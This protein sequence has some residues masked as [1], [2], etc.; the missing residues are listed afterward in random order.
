VRKIKEE[1]PSDPLR[2]RVNLPEPLSG[3]IL[4]CLAKSKEERFDSFDEICMHLSRIDPKPSHGSQKAVSDNW[5]AILD[6]AQ[7]EAA[8]C[9]ADVVA[10]AHLLLAALSYGCEP[11]ASWL[12]ARD[13]MED[14]ICDKIRASIDARPKANVS[15]TVRFRRSSRRVIGLA[16]SLAERETGTRPTTKHLIK[17]LLGEPSTRA[18][19][20]FALNASGAS[21]QEIEALFDQINEEF[22]RS[23]L[24]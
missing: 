8:R 10:P 24:D 2:L 7:S 3:V 15:A 19:L 20:A 9:G 14:S 5:T 11:L 17:P 1:I 18:T 12:S 23:D 21:D 16:H 22:E 13:I 6:K 4:K